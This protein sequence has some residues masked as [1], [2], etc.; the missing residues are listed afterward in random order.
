[1]A[2]KNIDYKVGEQVNCFGIR[3]V[4]AVKKKKIKVQNETEKGSFI[5]EWVP[6]SS[7]SLSK[8]E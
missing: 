6:I 4:I 8:I 1:M 7:L 5:V 2:S 3:E